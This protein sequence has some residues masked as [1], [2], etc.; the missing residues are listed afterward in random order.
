M[1]PDLEHMEYT[2]ARCRVVLSVAAL[3]VVYIDPE[4]PLI[5]QWIPFVTGRFTMDPRAFVVMTAYV[6]YSAIIYVGLR[7][8]WKLPPALL[9]HT[10]WTDV[11]FG[12]AIAVLTEGVTGPSYPFFAFAVVSSGMR[13]GLRQAMTVTSVNL[14]LYLL[15][16][17]FSREGN[18]N[19]YIMRPVYLGITG[20]LVGY[21]WQQRLELQEQTIELSKYV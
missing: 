6:V 7:R 2:I 21:L 4:A 9:A 19:I 8:G 17:L 20:Y 12:T 16:I 18:A 14:A 1:A 15:L 5:A 13:G 10:V 11:L 3:V